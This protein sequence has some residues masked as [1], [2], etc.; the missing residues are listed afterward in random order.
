MRATAY[1]LCLY[2]KHAFL[3]LLKTKSYSNILYTFLFSRLSFLHISLFLFL[4]IIDVR[5]QL[6]PLSHHHFPLACPP[7][8]PTLNPTPLWLCPW[9]LYTCSFMTLSLLSHI[10]SLPPNSGYCQ[11]VV[12]FKVSGYILALC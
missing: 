3:F 4:K 12:N 9:V 5:I 10:T 2:K 7:P 6:C 11:F 1:S 8:P